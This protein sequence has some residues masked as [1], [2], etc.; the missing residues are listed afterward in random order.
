MKRSSHRT[1]DKVKSRAI[2]VHIP[3]ELIKLLD[4]AAIKTK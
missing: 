3:P 4:E 2:I 1:P